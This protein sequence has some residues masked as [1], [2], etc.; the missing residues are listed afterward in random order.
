MVN[1]TQTRINVNAKEEKKKIKEKNNISFLPCSR[2]LVSTQTFC[3]E[4]KTIPATAKKFPN[5]PKP[6][7]TCVFSMCVCVLGCA[8]GD[9][10]KQLKLRCSLKIYEFDAHF[11][12]VSG[13]TVSCE[14]LV[15]KKCEYVNFPCLWMFQKRAIWICF[16]FTALLWSGLRNG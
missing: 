5:Q 15:L 6:N 7:E 4:P 10:V 8:S 11:E 1:S 12:S 3:G 9:G 16:F 14:W 2:F 13:W